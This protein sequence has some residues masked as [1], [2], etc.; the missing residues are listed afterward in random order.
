MEASVSEASVV[1]VPENETYKGVLCKME[2]HLPG[3]QLADRP[4]LEELAQIF[5][6]MAQEDL[7]MCKQEAKKKGLPWEGKLCL[8][9][10][11][12]EQD[13][14]GWGNSDSVEIGDGEIVLLS[15]GSRGIKETTEQYETRIALFGHE[16]ALKQVFHKVVKKFKNPDENILINEIC[17]EFST[18][19]KISRIASKRNLD[20]PPQE[21]GSFYYRPQKKYITHELQLA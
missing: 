8:F 3:F 12:R 14:F 21:M 17:V 2:C 16:Q 10:S 4:K 19:G 13:S 6:V 15:Q 1:V 20:Q 7:Q 5:L 18:D 9:G 11:F